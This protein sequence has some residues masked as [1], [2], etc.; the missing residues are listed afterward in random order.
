MRVKNC[1]YISTT[2]L[3]K[4]L[5]NDKSYYNLTLR[6]GNQ[7]VNINIIHCE[8]NRKE[9]ELYGMKG[10]QRIRVSGIFQKV[11][12]NSGY[13]WYFDFDGKYY[14]KLYK[15]FYANQ[16]VTREEANLIYSSKMVA[17]SLRPL[18]K[19]LKK[20]LQ[21]DELELQLEAKRRKVHYRGKYTPLA[22]KILKL[23]KEL[24]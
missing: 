8:E 17:P 23:R 22:Q 3:K 2:A 16:F 15:P 19:L 10:N 12:S 7:K 5:K 20:E 14:M 6:Q 13:R 9:L 4:Y 18:N 21:L 11:G 24:N 1:F